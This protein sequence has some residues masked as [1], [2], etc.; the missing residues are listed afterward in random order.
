MLLDP[1]QSFG[2]GGGGG[3]GGTGG[4]TALGAFMNQLGLSP[5]TTQFISM[6]TFFAGLF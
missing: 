6:D 5:D 3:G 2:S 4:G 1:F